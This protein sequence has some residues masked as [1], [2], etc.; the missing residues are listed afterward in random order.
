MTSKLV[1]SVVIAAAFFFNAMVSAQSGNGPERA[2]NIIAQPLQF[3][4]LKSAIDTIGTAEAQRSVSIY[5]ATSDIVTEVLFQP[6]D[7]VQS[8]QVLIKLDDRRQV[9][10]VE[11]AKIELADRE[12]TLTRL[13]ESKTRGAATQ[14]DVDDAITERDLAK[15]QLQ[16]AAADLEDRTVNAPFS[17]YL[18]LTD[19]EPGDRINTNTLITTID[20]RSNLYINFSAPESALTILNNEAIVTLSPWNNRGNEIT[21]EIAQIDSRINIQDRTL[22]VRAILDNQHDVYR[23]GLSFK[24]TLQLDGEPY[25]VIPEAALSWGATGAYVWIV[26]EGKANRERVN[27]VQRLRGNILV[28][29]QLQ[30]GE[31]LVIEGIQ[32]L[33]EGQAVQAFSNTGKKQLTSVEPG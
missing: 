21:A 13:K 7:F 19:V 22:K 28:E 24:V 2:A 8:G 30:R 18:G 5:P 20:D 3:Q 31:S 32:Q 12:R 16:S 1:F 17:G 9:I 11:R 27:I 25:P 33:R 15:V 29:G 23:P 26:R 14:S 6:G 4:P 10:A